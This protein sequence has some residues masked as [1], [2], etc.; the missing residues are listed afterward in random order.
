MAKASKKTSATRKSPRRTRD[1]SGG[2]TNPKVPR[3]KQAAKKKAVRKFA[4]KA[5]AKELAG[6]ETPTL[7]NQSQPGGPIPPKTPKLLGAS[8]PTGGPVNPKVP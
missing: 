1:S 7:A 6:P 4:G 8:D 3:R 2:P 5:S